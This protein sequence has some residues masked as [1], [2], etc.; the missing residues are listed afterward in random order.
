MRDLTG[1]PLEGM[2]SL[3]EGYDRVRRLRE[4]QRDAEARAR[5]IEPAKGEPE[6]SDCSEHRGEPPVQRSK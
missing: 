6:S 5:G 3:R 1:T 4:I 2:D